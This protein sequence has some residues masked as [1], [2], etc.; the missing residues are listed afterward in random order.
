LFYLDIRSLIRGEKMKVLNKKSIMSILMV[1]VALFATT[2]FGL[3]YQPL[4]ADANL[5]IASGIAD[6]AGTGGT[7]QVEYR[8]WDGGNGYYYYSYWIYNE[9][10]DLPNGAV[11]HL[12]VGNPSGMPY[13]VTGNGQGSRG[14]DPWLASDYQSQPVIV[15]WVAQSTSSGV[16]VGESSPVTALFQFASTLP[17]SSARL[18]LRQG[19]VTTYADGLI[20][21]PGVASYPR[22]TG[23]WK[24]QYSGKGQPKES[25]LLPGY[26]NTIEIGSPQVFG[27]GL[28]GTVAQ[29]MAFGL[30]ILNVDNNSDMLLKAKN[31][32]FALWLNIAS[33]KIGYYDA[34]AFDSNAVTTN[35]TTVKEAVE[36]I[37]ATILN[38][39][40]TLE[41]LENVKDI[42]EILNCM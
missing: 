10:F 1:G 26:M 19:S 37:E 11:R 24:H 16:F 17:P 38:T 13:I 6:A 15:D 40:A 23:Y 28:S 12:T 3:E 7:A 14:G 34:V 9:A 35:A 22:S 25:T 42:A 30:A 5:I 4:P 33:Q 39:S 20:V 27:P 8:V 2:A 32:L 18:T 21:A 36:Q 31:Q 41:E 29:D